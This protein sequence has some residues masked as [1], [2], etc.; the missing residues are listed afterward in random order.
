M[1]EEEEMENGRDNLESQ[2]VDGNE[3]K[4]KEEVETTHKGK[5]FAI[6]IAS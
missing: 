5:I 2:K 1:A 4:A 3:E 6:Y